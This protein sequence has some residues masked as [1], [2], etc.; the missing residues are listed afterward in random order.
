MAKR[1]ATFKKLREIQEESIRTFPEFPSNLFYKFPD[2]KRLATITENPRRQTALIISDKIDEYGSADPSKFSKKPIKVDEVTPMLEEVI[3]KVRPGNEH[4]ILELIKKLVKILNDDGL[5]GNYINLKDYSNEFISEFK[6]LF[7]K[8]FKLTGVNSINSFMVTSPESV[9]YHNTNAYNSDSISEILSGMSLLIRT[10]KIIVRKVLNLMIG[11]YAGGQVPV[12]DG[13]INKLKLYFG[14]IRFSVDGIDNLLNYDDTNLTP[15]VLNE[16][17]SI[18]P[19][20]KKLKLISARVLKIYPDMHKPGY[21]SPNLTLGDES[22]NYGI[23]SE[24]WLPAGVYK[25]NN[26]TDAGN[27]GTVIIISKVVNNDNSR[28][29]SVFKLAPIIEKS[30]SYRTFDDQAGKFRMVFK[31]NDAGDYFKNSKI[32]G[33][34]L[35]SLFAKHEAKLTT[36]LTE[37]EANIVFEIPN[38]F[39]CYMGS[40]EIRFTITSN[41]DSNVPVIENTIEAFP[42]YF[43]TRSPNYMVN[44]G[45]DDPRPQ[46]DN[47]IY[48]LIKEDLLEKFPELTNKTFKCDNPSL[49]PDV[50]TETIISDVYDTNIEGDPFK[51]FSINFKNPLRQLLPF[52]PRNYKIND[53]LSYGDFSLVNYIKIV[54]SESVVS[55]VDKNNPENEKVTTLQ[56]FKSLPQQ[57]KDTLVKLYTNPFNITIDNQDIIIKHKISEYRN[58]QT[59]ETLMLKANVNGT[60]IEI[61]TI[62]IVSTFTNSGKINFDTTRVKLPLDF[63]VSFENES[64][65]RTKYEIILHS[66]GN[67]MEGIPEYEVIIR[68]GATASFIN[69][70][71]SDSNCLGFQYNIAKQVTF[72]VPLRVLSEDWEVTQKSVTL[73]IPSVIVTPK[74]YE[75][76]LVFLGKIKY[77]RSERL[78]LITENKGSDYTIVAGNKIKCVQWMM[79]T[80]IVYNVY[81]V[82]EFIHQSNLHPAYPGT[83]YHIKNTIII[84]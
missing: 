43:V 40:K 45:T 62:S 20:N 73:T 83:A 28:F 24:F 15:E 42:K 47:I 13:L 70:L 74:L 80:G 53:I 69:G 4:Y 9:V 33:G 12:D 72:N 68:S 52:S 78:I 30:D 39:L 44:V 63:M 41:S 2:L 35:L 27:Y 61:P 11:G 26:R 76:E 81:D 18:L 57:I 1:L 60:E 58:K 82:S 16:N 56:L 59:A 5:E 37:F 55:I 29:D 6:S 71:S 21:K 8:V 46:R 51:I 23:Y 49:L 67:L 77:G 34:K 10:K 3:F 14:Q 75:N 64:Y 19:F 36:Y 32:S 66:S 25:I 38:K 48:A 31:S 65:S 7:Y 50:F 79:S 17:Y 22:E 54:Q 84:N